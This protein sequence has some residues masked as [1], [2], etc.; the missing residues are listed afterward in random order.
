MSPTSIRVLGAQ[1]DAEI[2]DRP[3]GAD[4]TVAS[5]QHDKVSP[6]SDH[7]PIPTTGSGVVRAIDV[8]VTRAQGDQITEAMRLSRDDRIKY[9]IYN[10]RTFSRDWKWRSYT[11]P[12][13][14]DSHFHLSTIESGDDDARAWQLGTGQPPIV[15]TDMLPLEPTSATEDIRSLQNR[16]NLAYSSGLS[17]D[18]VWG[19]STSA[20]VKA[21]LGT[22]TGDPVAQE[23]RRVVARQWDQILIDLIARH[24]GSAGGIKRGDSVRLQ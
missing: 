15:E 12:A 16:L 8:T 24:G 1:I 7:R 4:G 18:G 17:L 10:R 22:L 2:S 23:G 5:K 11:G 13:P 6:N 21:N 9:V 3:T 14:H 19:D 20:A